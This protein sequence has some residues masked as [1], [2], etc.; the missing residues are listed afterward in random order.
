[1]QINGQNLHLGSFATSLVATAAA[2]AVFATSSTIGFGCE[3]GN[4]NENPR[5]MFLGTNVVEQKEG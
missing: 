4:K 5:N 2:A 3:S 1:M